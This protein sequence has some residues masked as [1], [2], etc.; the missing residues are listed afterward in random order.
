MVL[1]PQLVLLLTNVLSEL[2]LCFSFFCC[3]SFPV[4]KRCRVFDTSE[5][6]EVTWYEPLYNK[7]NDNYDVTL[8]VHLLMCIIHTL[9]ILL[10]C[11]IFCCATILES[12]AVEFNK[13]SACCPGD[14]S[15]VCQSGRIH[16]LHLCR[17][18]RLHQ[19]LS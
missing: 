16:Q 5:I 6:P 10:H 19:R 7:N 4:L 8:T 11:C 3:F 18:V 17:G 14:G 13:C 12:H 15:P 1:R 2:S 9:C